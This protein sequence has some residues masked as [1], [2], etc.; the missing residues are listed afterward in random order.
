M[1]IFV[2]QVLSIC[3]VLFL[4]FDIYK[5]FASI[6]EQ[7]LLKEKY[8]KGISW[9][10][11]KAE[12]FEV[13]NNLIKEPRDKYNELMEDKKLIDQLLDEGAQKA[14]VIA[15]SNLKNLKKHLLG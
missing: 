14:R 11:A 13:L 8:A 6:D 5:S 1:K 2:I 4:V 15:Q 12:L 9:G 7:E 10:E 3:W